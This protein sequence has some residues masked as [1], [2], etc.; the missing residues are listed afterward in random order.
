[1]SDAAGP[2]GPAS[3]KALPKAPPNQPGA[4]MACCIYLVFAGATPLGGSRSWRQSVPSMRSEVLPP[5]T[6][7]CQQQLLCAGLEQAP[8]VAIV[9]AGVSG[10][11]LARTLQRHRISHVVL[12]QSAGVGG[13]WKSATH[14]QGAQGQHKHENW[15]LSQQCLR[16]S[17][18]RE[19]SCRS[20]VQ[21]LSRW[22][23]CKILRPAR[24]PSLF[25]RKTTRLPCSSACVGR[26]ES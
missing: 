4:T 9:G 19:L 5:P 16:K 24:T 17:S 12:E 25:C 2:Q 14:L 26:L 7:H 23:R 8:D 10:L 1:M 11:V 13:V 6:M 18:T 21:A 20:L 22:M 3:F 15:I